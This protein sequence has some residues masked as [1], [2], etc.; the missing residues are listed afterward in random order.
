MRKIDIARKQ[1]QNYEKSLSSII[2]KIEESKHKAITDE[3][4][5]EFLDLSETFSEWQY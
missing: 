5:L 4:V 3:Y 2:K 1:I